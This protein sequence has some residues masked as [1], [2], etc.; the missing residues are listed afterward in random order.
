MKK[1]FAAGIF[2]LAL[3]IS[4]AF[5]Q[6][7]EYISPNNDG[8]KDTLEI[9]LSIKEK[10]YVSAWSLTICNRDGKIVRVI[11]NKRQDETKF[12]FG[13]FFRALITPKTGVEIPSSISWNG[14]LGDEAEEAGLVPGSVAPDGEY[15]YY[16]SVTDD[17]GNTGTTGKYKVIVDNTPPSISL[18]SLSDTDKAF[19]EGS[20]VTLKIPQL[21][22]NELKWVAKILDASGKTVIER[23]WNNQ[24]P[25]SIFEWDGADSAKTIVPDG[26]YSYA[27]SGVDLAGNVSDKAV[28][29]NIIF[30]AEKPV[31]A[32]SIDGSKY[33]SPNGDKVQ[34]EISFAVDI[35]TPRS[36][37]N[38]LSAW[39]L[40]ILDAASDKVV[41]DVSGTNNPISA[42]KFNG[43]DK[44]GSVL[45]DGEYRARVKAK[46]LNGYEPEPVYSARFVLD[47]VTPK[48]AVFVSKENFNGSEPLVISQKTTNSEKEYTGA[49][50]WKGMVIDEKSKVVKNFD[51]GATLPESLSW[52]FTNDS[53][54]FVK[55][56]TYSYELSVT[57]PAGNSGKYTASSKFTLDTS[58]TEVRLVVANE[59]FSPNADN[60][61]DTVTF[62]PE[63]KASSGVA[64]Y[65]LIIRDSKE[66][67]VKTFAGENSVPDS[68]TWDG[69]NEA[70]NIC[71]DGKYSVS[72]VTKAKNGTSSDVVKQYCLID[73]AVPFIE[74]SADYLTFSPDGLSASVSRKQVLPVTVKS[75]TK[76]DK[77]TATISKG[78]SVVRT[79]EWTGGNSGV[80]VSNFRW[81][82]TDNNGNRCADATYSMTVSATDAAGN[83]G[84]STISN[85][86]LDTR[87]TKSY[88]TA[89]LEGISPNGDGVLESQTF[90]LRSTLSDGVAKWHF[91]VA[92]SRGNVVRTWNE[93]TSR[94]LPKELVWDGKTA[95]GK[96]AE[97]LFSGKLHVEY[98]KGN[99]IDAE[100]TSFICT[101]T[102]PKL[103]VDSSSNPD[104]G[105]YFSPDNDGNEDELDMKLYCSTIAEVKTWSLEI[106]NSRDG[107]V[108]W[109]TNGKSMNSSGKPNSYGAGIV[110]DGRGNNG[111]MV[112]SAEDYP[113][114]YTVTD[115]LGMTSVYKGI[116]SVDVLVI[117]D[118]GKLKMQVPAIVFRS[119]NADFL[120]NGEIDKNGK[121]VK[122]SK[123]TA[124]QKA[125]NERVLMRIAQILKKFSSY[126]VTVVGHANPIAS[127]DE[128]ELLP[129]SKERA[130]YVKEWLV[131]EGKI[132]SGRL[133]TEGMG[134]KKTIVPMNDKKN[135]WKNRRVEFIL[136]K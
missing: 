46:Y 58:K 41:L 47:T 43:A 115:N 86:V 37:V 84:K 53:G 63:V 104:K 61:K 79:I 20:K 10:R 93:N 95:G 105:K 69:K 87:E 82:G 26:V 123:I 44:N 96:S 60:V 54:R 116:I 3:C 2:A 73:T 13:S 92:D 16:V 119:D 38:G 111:E 136:E 117:L 23:T 113:Y 31:I 62:S 114:E 48:A 76:E 33:F 94:S 125:N 66:T 19:G 8:V 50:I 106:K 14:F 109:K 75:C 56:G 15:F 100:S 40:E 27:I 9:P 68:I 4:G 80:A 101:A 28:V 39:S 70:G 18:G 128:P 99:V 126:K 59:C 129:L 67:V 112:M 81:D 30:S 120:M 135:N 85:I 91:D 130:D 1:I 45:A 132:S 57:E 36:K 42:Y 88:V 49:K 21:G 17:N 98:E 131:K 127:N 51:F 74:M 72:F 65:S 34:D 55:D 5:A 102:A 118:N 11:G 78:N 24:S 12:T 122:N 89:S 7:V 52:D 6:R 71:D 110:W 108:F 133:S 32:I 121:V 97:G 134:G 29:S 103:T 107:S 35:P 77:W 25:P 90:T 124:E 83:Y 64:S 22:S